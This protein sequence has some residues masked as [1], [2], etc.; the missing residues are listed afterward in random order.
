MFYIWHDPSFFNHFSR[1]IPCDISWLDHWRLVSQ[2]LLL[3]NP[4]SEVMLFSPASWINTIVFSPTLP[5]LFT[6]PSSLLKEEDAWSASIFHSFSPSLHEEALMPRWFLNWAYDFL[7]DVLS[8]L[9]TWQSRLMWK[10]WDSYGKPEL[11]VHLCSG[12]IL[13]EWG[14]VLISCIYGNVLITEK[15]Y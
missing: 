14:H 9:N 15:K 1:G 10:S 5:S 8:V 13:K 4:P 7:T 3:S 11:R 2:G 6:I 12:G